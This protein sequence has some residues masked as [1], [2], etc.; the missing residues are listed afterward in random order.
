MKLALYLVMLQKANILL[1]DEPTNHLDIINVAWVKNYLNSLTEVTAIIVTHESD[2]LNDYC[3]H[4]LQIENL[5]L[6]TFK[7]RLGEFVKI[8]PSARA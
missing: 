8:K 6:H 7:G 1:L 2:F 4:I 5:K 3:T